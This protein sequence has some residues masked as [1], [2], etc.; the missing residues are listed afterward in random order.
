MPPAFSFRAKLPAYDAFFPLSYFYDK[1][2]CTPFRKMQYRYQNVC[3]QLQYH[4]VVRVGEVKEQTVIQL[5]CWTTLL[6]LPTLY[7]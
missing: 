2:Y 3:V 4:D 1:R 5:Y 6:S 7:R